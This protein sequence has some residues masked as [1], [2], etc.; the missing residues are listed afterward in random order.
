MKKLR[1]VAVT[2]AREAE[3]G[4]IGKAKARL[5]ISTGAGAQ[6]RSPAQF[7]A[8]PTTISQKRREIVYSVPTRIDWVANS[9]RRE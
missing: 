1:Q 9:Y 2:L 5:P 8:E 3:E 4:P 7:S 6:A